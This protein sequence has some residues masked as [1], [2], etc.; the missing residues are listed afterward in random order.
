MK[1]ASYIAQ[2]NIARLRFPLDAPEVAE[3]VAALEPLNALADEAPGFVWRL[4][5]ETGD[6]TAVQAFD[7]PN[8]IVNMSVWTSIGALRAYVFGGP[9]L[10]IVKRRRDWFEPLGEAHQ[11]LW[12]VPPHVRPTVSQ[13]T[14]RLSQL[15]AFGPTPAAFT[16]AHEYPPPVR[17]S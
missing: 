10:E 2:L 8:V 12:W 16:F 3:F 14:A 5:T 7:D 6:A 15:R 17:A 1:G 11:V 9:H 4:Q 13:A